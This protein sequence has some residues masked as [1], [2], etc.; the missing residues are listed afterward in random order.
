MLN[1]A[2]A[3]APRPTLNTAI[4]DG[5]LEPAGTTSIATDAAATAA[6]AAAPA[7]I[8]QDAVDPAPAAEIR[9]VRLRGE[10]MC[11]LRFPDR[12]PAHNRR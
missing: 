1:R 7:L 4:T 11:A 8:I 2:A 9:R 6:A 12:S 5:R 10:D 3:E